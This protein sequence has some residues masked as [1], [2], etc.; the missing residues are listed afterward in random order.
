MAITSPRFIGAFAVVGD[1][2]QP[3]TPNDA[4]PAAAVKTNDLLVDVRQANTSMWPAPFNVCKRTAKISR[5]ARLTYHVRNRRR[6]L[7]ASYCSLLPSSFLTDSTNAAVF[8]SS[9]TSFVTSDRVASC[10]NPT[11]VCVSV[12]CSPLADTSTCFRSVPG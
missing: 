5:L 12:C 11:C 6:Q 2:Q 9:T 1:A 7:A 4:I 10:T 8:I 3:R